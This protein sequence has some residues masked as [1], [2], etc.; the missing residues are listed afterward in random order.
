MKNWR[1]GSNT[2]P[3]LYF[4]FIARSIDA[5]HIFRQV[6]G[7]PELLSQVAYVIVN[8]LPGIEG[9]VL[10]PYQIQQHFTV[11]YM[12]WVQYE[13]SKNLKFLDRQRNY[14]APHSNKTLLH[15]EIQITFP[16]LRQQ[17]ICLRRNIVTTSK[18]RCIWD[19]SRNIV[20]LIFTNKLSQLFLLIG[21][22]QSIT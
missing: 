14:L 15:T 7:N 9:I 8:R 18:E 10:M 19:I 3:F 17:R 20:S 6:R 2:A 22:K 16:D 11:E 13:Q 12:F 21:G 1:C 5:F 4:K